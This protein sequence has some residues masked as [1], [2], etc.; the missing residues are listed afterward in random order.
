G[1]QSTRLAR[2]RQCHLSTLADHLQFAENPDLQHVASLPRPAGPRIITADYAVTTLSRQLSTLTPTPAHTVRA[3]Y[4]IAKGHPA[5]RRR[6]LGMMDT[7]SVVPS[8]RYAGCIA[9]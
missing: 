7:S 4:R 8:E 9:S 2:A 1:E 5:P 6:E 3:D